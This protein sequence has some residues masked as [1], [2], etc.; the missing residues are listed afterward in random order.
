MDANKRH[1]CKIV[2]CDVVDPVRD[3]LVDRLV[4]HGKEGFVKVYNHFR[5]KYLRQ[6]CGNQINRFVLGLALFRV[7]MSR[8]GINFDNYE[9]AFD[10][11]NEM[12][13]EY[14]GPRWKARY[15]RDFMTV[16]ST[17]RL[18]KR[19]EVAV[20]T[21]FVSTLSTAGGRSVSDFDDEVLGHVQT[22][23]LAGPYI[24][25]NCWPTN[26]KR[27]V[28]VNVAGEKLARESAAVL[29]DKS[30]VD[31][32]IVVEMDRDVTKE[33]VAAAH[34]WFKMLLD[35]TDGMPMIVATPSVAF[36]CVRRE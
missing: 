36:V 11:A 22:T 4:P 5:N 6:K 15:K 12:G 13:L 1:A 19:I 14:Y 25:K 20:D 7:S 34:E 9:Q 32:D 8:L 18:I 35:N 33:S 30:V 16:S 2:V 3:A 31:C 24:I 10:I 29:A 21:R 28:V 23:Q 27:L 17:I 26:V